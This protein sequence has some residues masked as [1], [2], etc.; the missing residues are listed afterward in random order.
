[1]KN[2][3]DKLNRLENLT[4]SIKD[5]SL[6]LED[7]LKVFEEGIQLVRGMEKELDKI[8][9]KVEVLMNKP[10]TKEEKPKTES[11]DLFSESEY[12]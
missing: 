9:N 2:F 8:E 4:E 7:A 3:E 12:W 1:M 6:S 10:A 5:P 11:L